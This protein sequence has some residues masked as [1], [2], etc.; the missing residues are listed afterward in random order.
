M[1]DL[2]EISQVARNWLIK[3]G[4]IPPLFFVFGDKEKAVCIF[5]EFPDTAEGRAKVA[6]ELGVNVAKEK[7]EEIG[8][9]RSVVF[10]SEAWM[11]VLKKDEKMKTTP[12]KDPKRIEV[13]MV[14]GKEILN[15]KTNGVIFELVRDK[16]GK[17]I[18]LEHYEDTENKS[19]EMTLESMQIEAFLF[20]Y[21]KGQ[22]FK[23]SS[24]KQKGKTVN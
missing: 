2:L 1:K 24:L 21:S 5:E 4:E 15:K 6:L 13:L 22:M 10:V 20:G 7:Q 16:K 23:E 12:S 3:E 17:I 9:L 14:T 11:S 8:N 18:K 19:D